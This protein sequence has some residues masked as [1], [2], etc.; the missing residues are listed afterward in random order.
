VALVVTTRSMHR[1]LD[2]VRHRQ[3]RPLSAAD[4][5]R[6][7]GISVLARL[8]WTEDCR[9]FSTAIVST[10]ARPA[11]SACWDTGSS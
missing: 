3:I 6:V 2:A 5:P 1:E 4:A 10:S 11:R 9:L 7:A 8:E